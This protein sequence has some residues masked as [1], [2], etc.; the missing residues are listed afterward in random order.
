MKKSK[1]LLFNNVLSILYFTYAFGQLMDIVEK[2]V[3]SAEKFGAGITLMLISP[4]LFLVFLAMIFGW[5]GYFLKRSGF[6]LTSAI[7]YCVAA[8]LFIPLAVYV[9]PMIIIGFVAYSNI[10]KKTSKVAV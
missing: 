8:G 5:L 3:D 10:K 1:L 9:L 4:H 6:A 7:L 2:S